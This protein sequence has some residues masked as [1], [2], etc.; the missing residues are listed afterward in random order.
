MNS[1]KLCTA[2]LVGVLGACASP[3][4]APVLLT[5]PPAVALTAGNV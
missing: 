1:L 5:L 3:S 2:L 4:P